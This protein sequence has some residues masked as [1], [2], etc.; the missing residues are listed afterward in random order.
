MIGK[1]GVSLISLVIS[2][3]VMLIIAATLIYTGIESTKTEKA[4]K[5][6]ADIQALQD[7]VNNYYM[8]NYTIPVIYI[9]E[10]KKELEHSLMI[11]ILGEDRNIDDEDIYYILDISKLENVT[12]SGE[13]QRGTFIINDVTHTV[14]YIEEVL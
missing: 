7:S 12:L 10:D 5:I 14:Y 8:K 2:L 11:S 6:N 3:V 4:S 1:R 9:N 13:T